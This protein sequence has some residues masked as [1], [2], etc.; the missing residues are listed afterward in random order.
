MTTLLLTGGAGFIGQN[1]VH[2]LA[3]T[4]P[5][6]DIIVLDALTYAANPTSLEPL[7]RSGAVRLIQGDIAN[8]EAI[9][10]VFQSHDI[11][12]VAHLAAESHVDRSISGPDA[13]LQTN[14]IGTYN[15][16]K[17]ALSTWKGRGMLERARFL[18]VSTDEVFGDLELDD[19]PF[20]ETSPYRPSSPYSATKAASDHLASAFHR[21]Y[22]LPV[23]ITNCSNNY[24]PYQHPE[25]LIP[26]MTLHALQGKPLPIY[27]NG[28]NIRDWLYVGDHCE[29]LKLALEKGVPGESY[30]IG[31]GAEMTNLQVVTEICD[32]IDRRFAERPALSQQYP[33]CPPATGASSHSLITYVQDRAGH[34]RR[35]AINPAFSQKALGYRPAETFESGLAITIDWYIENDPWWRQALSEEFS[36]WMSRNYGNRAS[37]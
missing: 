23:V 33:Q 6:L 3:G 12:A 22:G 20:A 27:G 15:L 18:H 26:L 25:K 28:T 16:L 29:A 24:G 30:N 11:S 13:F 7:L 10:S 9:Q 36:E 32:H 21:T 4:R 17:C 35:Y 37:A 14:V 19:P 34:D 31:G 2:H 1:L 8:L 5:D